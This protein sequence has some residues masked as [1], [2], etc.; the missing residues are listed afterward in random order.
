MRSTLISALNNA[1]EAKKLVH[2]KKVWDTLWCN[3]VGIRHR[4]KINTPDVPNKLHPLI[5][6]LYLLIGARR[7]A[8]HSDWREKKKVVK[9]S[10]SLM[11]AG[12]FGDF[13]ALHTLAMRFINTIDC[14]T[15]EKSL[16]APKS[17]SFFFTFR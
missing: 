12:C 3:P 4:L 1:D 10:A 11:L 9:A 15:V 16:L 5:P 7:F 14:A 17:L 8:E 6:S 2:Q 13:H